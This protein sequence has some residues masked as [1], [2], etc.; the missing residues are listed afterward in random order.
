IKSKISFKKENFSNL[1]NIIKNFKYTSLIKTHNSFL[2]SSVI[3]LGLLVPF[4]QYKNIKDNGT[5]IL[6]PVFVESHSNDF[7][8]EYLKLKY[9]NLLPADEINNLNGKIVVTT[10]TH[11]RAIFAKPYNPLEKLKPHEYILSYKILNEGK[12]PKILYASNFIRGKK[13]AKIISYAEVKVI[14]NGTALLVDVK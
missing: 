7:I 4:I 8:S 13:F 11:N 14:P 6:L 3:V 5:T 12:E 1:F 10:D 2:I 9:M